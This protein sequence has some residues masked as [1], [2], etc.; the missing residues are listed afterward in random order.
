MGKKGGGSQN[1]TMRLD[2][3]T[4]RY[5]DRGRRMAQLGSRRIM[6]G[7]GGLM[8]PSMAMRSRLREIEGA[9]G[10]GLDYYSDLM[11]RA[12][13]AMDNLGFAMGP[14]DP[15]QLDAYMNPYLDKVGGAVRGEFGHLRDVADTKA[16]QEAT[17]A[18]AGFGSRAA[19]MRGERAGQL[20]RAQATTMADIY[21]GGFKEAMANLMQ[22]RTRTGQ[23]A[24]GMGGLGAQAA[25]AGSQF[26]L[27]RGQAGLQGR[28]M[29]RALRE[30][31]I[32]EPLWRYQQ[33]MNLRNLGMGPYGSS[34]AGGGGGSGAV[35]SALGGA[36][37]GFGIGGP[38]GGLI[39][40][41]IGLLGGLFG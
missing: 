4:Q 26:E 20:D 31:N 17:G 30:R 12:G 34:Q 40:G 3:R 37:T 36:A 15:S 32:N 6:A 22:D 13:G 41:G 8:G 25:G 5:V 7:Q 16:M 10:A 28:E 9:G 11:Q 19:V 33:A 23:L 14:L 29:M 18:G 21:S 27:M 38:V 35:A 24:L 39:G 2:P 1:V